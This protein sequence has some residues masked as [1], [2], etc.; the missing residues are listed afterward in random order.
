MLPLS[1]YSLKTELNEPQIVK[2]F[3]VREKINP[4]IFE[5]LK[6]VLTWTNPLGYY[7]VL[8]DKG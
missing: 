5:T 3:A 4:V 6:T 8:T 1:Q 2:P 7:A